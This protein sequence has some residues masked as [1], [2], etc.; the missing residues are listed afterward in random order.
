MSKRMQ[1]L[2]FGALMT[3]ILSEYRD[4]GSILG[5]SK[6]YRA[7]GGA[8]PIFGGWI[9]TPFG[10]AA[11]PHTRL[12]Q[13]IISA[14]LTGSR[15][16]ELRTVRRDEG[17]MQPSG[18]FAEHVRAWFAMKLISRE[19]GIG[20]PEGFVFNMSLVCEGIDSEEIDEYIENMKNAAETAVWDEC[21]SWT[22]ENLPMFMRVKEEYV[23]SISPVVSR[24]DTLVA[25]CGVEELERSAEYLLREKGLHTWIKLGP[26]MLEAGAVREKLTKL[27]Y[28]DVVPDETG[29]KAA[30]SLVEILPM[31]KRLNAYALERGLEFGVKLTGALPVRGRDG[32]GYLSGRA[33]LPI[34][35]SLAREVSEATEGGIRISYS[36]GADVRSIRTLVGAGTWPVTLA[37]ELLKPGGYER[38]SQFSEEIGFFAPMGFGGVDFRALRNLE[39]ETLE[40]EYYRKR[41]A[42]P[43]SVKNSEKLPVFGCA[44]APC[45]KACPLGQDIPAFLRMVRDERFGEALRVIME[46]NPLPN[47]TGALCR[48]E[49]MPVCMRADYEAP[50]DMRA[51]LRDVAFQG[52]RQAR[53]ML[54]AGEPVPEKRTAIIGAG[55]AG[56]ALAAF[57]AR[58]GIDTT[59]F[60]KQ[61]EVGGMAR[62]AVAEAGGEEFAVERDLQFITDV[63]A[64]L[65]TGVEIRS[66]AELRNR[67]FTDIIVAS[68]EGSALA[69]EPGVFVVGGAGR[70]MRSVVE[71][72]ADAQRAARELAG[73]SLETF[74]RLNRGDRTT[75]LARHS[76]V[77]IY[78]ELTEAEKCLECET[79]CEICVEIC[80]NR[81]NVPVP[82]SPYGNREVVHI[83]ALCSECG[84]CAVFCPW[85]GEPFRGKFTL[86]SEE[87]SFAASTN[88]GVLIRN[89][90]VLR[91]R[92]SEPSDAADGLI[93]ALCR[94]YKYLL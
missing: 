15:F 54:S 65:E 39:E 4:E 86:F 93:E 74:S 16:F 72:V 20:S 1:T 6:Y 34:A 70:E 89:G 81:A 62:R 8:R 66:A 73:I 71:A 44:V 61:N 30:L 46:K 78:G 53:Q 50:V 48:G 2:S 84:A 38:M 76:S 63:G 92:V 91:K 22:L 45:R 7:E 59:I 18:A 69:S 82:T 49:C 32:A 75:G 80:P 68:G 19:L 42:R 57:L 87:E 55:P 26:E 12:S 56:L 11:G 67:G 29:F 10:P 60:E 94:D 13:N 25:D 88:D 27:G 41:E 35:V 28:A 64:K 77:D 9:E 58:A 14:Y 83:D 79:V 51:V 90:A 52:H 36:G 37:D 43:K 33:L 31:L 23:R 85:G 3:R 47:I 5:I 17:E 24:S 40:D 21:L